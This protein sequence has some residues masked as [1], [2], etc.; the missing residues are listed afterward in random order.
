MAA[1][2]TGAF[3]DFTAANTI[4]TG[5][6]YVGG[7]TVS[8]T[9]GLT[10]HNVASAVQSALQANYAT[11]SA[12]ESR[13]VVNE[14]SGTITITYPDESPSVSLISYSADSLVGISTTREVNQV[15]DTQAV[16]ENNGKFLKAGELTLV[17]PE[18]TLQ[19]T[20]TFGPAMTASTQNLTFGAWSAGTNNSFSITTKGGSSQDVVGN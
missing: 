7:V 9:P 14:G 8:I 2:T 15:V 6:I 11:S 3:D 10:A 1:D 17:L 16:F 5:N 4:T 12:T 19:R 18:P 13:V 20:I